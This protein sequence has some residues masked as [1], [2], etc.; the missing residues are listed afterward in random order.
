MIAPA[1]GIISSNLFHAGEHIRLG[2]SVATIVAT[3]TTHIIGYLRQSSVVS[4]KINDEV[5]IR[6]RL[7]PGPSGSARILRIGSDVGFIN[8]ALQL[9]DPARREQALK[10]IVSIPG[11]LSLRPGEFVDISVVNK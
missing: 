2:D 9:S 10:V 1:D 6:S 5:R 3:N 8:P 7:F 4:I 11:D